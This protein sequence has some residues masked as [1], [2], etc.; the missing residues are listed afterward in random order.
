[1]IEN[2]IY[3]NKVCYI[4]D[5]L[6]KFNTNIFAG[7]FAFFANA[8]VKRKNAKE[9]ASQRKRALQLIQDSPSTEKKPSR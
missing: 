2:F 3:H 9:P 8:K 6:L 7:T 1:M 4:S 5:K